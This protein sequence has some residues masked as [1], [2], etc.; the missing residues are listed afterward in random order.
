MGAG[1]STLP[2]PAT[3]EQEKREARNARTRAKRRFSLRGRLPAGVGFA[4]P[5]PRPFFRPLRLFLARAY[6]FTLRCDNRRT[7][8]HCKRCGAFSGR[9]L[10]AKLVGKTRGGGFT[11]S[12]S[13]ALDLR[14]RAL[15]SAKYR[16]PL[17]PTRSPDSVLSET[18]CFSKTGRDCGRRLCARRA[19]KGAR[20]AFLLIKR[21]AFAKRKRLSVN[22]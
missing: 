6:P 1:R 16:T 4:L 14:P 22:G 13:H 10:F 2:P 7:V 12:A 18:L 3:C 9:I 21:R 19:G 5:R 20:W 17:L 8:S 15:R 11:V